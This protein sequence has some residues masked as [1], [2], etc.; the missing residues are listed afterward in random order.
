MHVNKKEY[1]REKNTPRKQK[2]LN[3][4]HNVNK[5]WDTDMSMKYF[6][7]IFTLLIKKMITLYGKYITKI[8]TDS[9]KIMQK[10]AV[11]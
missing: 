6:F 2:T 10:V 1:T 9:L 7:R 3:V 5:R 4:K 8:P 11:E